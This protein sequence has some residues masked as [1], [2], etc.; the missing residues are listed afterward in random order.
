MIVTDG[1]RA[2]EP[3]PR[4]DPATLVTKVIQGITTSF[5]REMGI[6][7]NV[8]VTVT[9]ISCALDVRMIEVLSE[10]AGIVSYSVRVT[11]VIQASP[12]TQEVSEC[13]VTVIVTE[14]IRAKATER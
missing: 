9:V 12:P 1:T 2:R 6:L 3:N 13:C 5:L 11:R 7:F 4:A 10:D 14:V 8:D